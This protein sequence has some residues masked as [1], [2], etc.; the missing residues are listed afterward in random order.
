MFRLGGEC[1]VIQTLL[2]SC[3][4]CPDRSASP[5]L[6]KFCLGKSSSPCPGR[7]FRCVSVLYLKVQVE[8]VC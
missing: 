8:S 4:L 7:F 5:S 1:W 2:E 6:S 3:M